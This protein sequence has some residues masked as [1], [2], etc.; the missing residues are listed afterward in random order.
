MIHLLTSIEQYFL[1]SK[2]IRR[3]SLSVFFNLLYPYII[4]NLLLTIFFLVLNKIS[5]S[6]QENSNIRIQRVG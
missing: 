6:T 5:E 3:I 4:N 1:W 2:K